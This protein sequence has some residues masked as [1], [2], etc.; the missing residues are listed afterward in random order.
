MGIVRFDC[1]SGTYWD[2]TQRREERQREKRE[3]DFPVLLSGDPFFKSTKPFSTCR[4]GRNMML[5]DCDSRCCSLSELCAFALNSLSLSSSYQNSEICNV[6]QFERF[7]Q[8]ICEMQGNRDILSDPGFRCRWRS[9]RRSA[10]VFRS[11]NVC[12]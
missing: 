1:K 2:S 6:T 11:E 3:Q 10:A 7:T 12:H 8:R 5:H 4:L 9:N